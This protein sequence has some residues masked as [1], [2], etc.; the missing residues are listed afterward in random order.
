MCYVLFAAKELYFFILCVCV[1]FPTVTIC[2]RN[3]VTLDMI[4]YTAE[5]L[6]VS[7]MY[8]ILSDL[9]RSR[10]ILPPPQGK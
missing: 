5:A 9:Y 7:D 3:L 4:N 8:E 10:S 2:N 1:Q 6:N